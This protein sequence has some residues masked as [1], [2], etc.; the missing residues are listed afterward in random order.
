M[1]E[2]RHKVVLVGDG[3]V[4]SSFA[5]S[6]LQTTPEVDELIIIDR[7]EDKA[8]GDSLDLQDITPLESP[9]IIRPG[10]HADAK[11][12]D[13]VV[14]TAGVPRKPGETRLDL[15]NKNTAILKSIV[16]PI[17][18]S[19]FNGIFLVSS[20]P[21]DILTTLTQKISGFP[22]ERVIGTGTSLDTARLNVL[23]SQKLNI[24][25][26]E[27]DALI[28]GEHG[29]TS[30]GAFDEA[31]ING[32]PLKEVAD[33]TAED[34]EAFEDAV[35]KRGGEIIS[36]KGATFYGVA[37]CLAHIVK[38]IIENRNIMLPV[39][40][41]LNGEYGVKDL[42]LGVPAIINTSGIFKVVDYD[43]SEEESKKM[44]HSAAE[45]K[46]VLDSVEL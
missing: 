33:L 5:Y 7:N 12:A 34:Y 25:V 20:N 36:R 19:G 35:R 40:A 31:T 32:K 30:F 24:P 14:I 26:N 2:R 44:L 22:K 46:K 37:K 1:N 10:V 41:P 13:V 4:G 17:V 9:T 6:L 29:D 39:S 18:A 42:Y 8:A 16:D 21:V 45:M 43:L 27:I 11:D 15:I 28:L 23:L 3:A 38:A